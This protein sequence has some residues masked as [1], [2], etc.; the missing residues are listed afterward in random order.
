MIEDQKI[1]FEEQLTKKVDIMND[2]LKKLLRRV[3]EDFGRYGEYDEVPKYAQVRLA[4][5]PLPLS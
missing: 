4:F 2:D 5:R 1:Q 3:K